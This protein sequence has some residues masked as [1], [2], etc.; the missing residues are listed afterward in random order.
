MFHKRVF[1]ASRAS[2][3]LLSAKTLTQLVVFHGGRCSPN[4]PPTTTT[5]TTKRITDDTLGP[6]RIHT[7]ICEPIT[8]WASDLFSIS[9]LLAAKLQS[10]RCGRLLPEPL[11]PVSEP[12]NNNTAKRQRP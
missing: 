5:H 12:N 3:L 7:H 8:L 4:E 6:L 11:N 10:L 9:R 2:G 1:F